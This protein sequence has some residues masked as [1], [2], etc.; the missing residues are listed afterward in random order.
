MEEKEAKKPSTTRKPRTP[1]PVVDESPDMDLQA[2]MQQM[3]AMM[4]AQ[5]Q[6]IVELMKVQQDKKQEAPGIEEPTRKTKKV[7]KDTGRMNKQELRRKYK[8][9]D[10]YV[11]NVSQG[12]VLHKAKNNKYEWQNPGDIEVMSIEDVINMPRAFLHTPWLCIDPYENDEEMVDDIINALALEDVYEYVYILQELD[13][14]INSVGV[15]EIEH[16]INL[17][18]KHG[19]DISVDIAI[20]VERKIR[21]K[22]LTNYHT[23]AE[24]SKILGRNFM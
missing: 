15:D 12:I 24:L 6:Q 17:S 7:R 20:L 5:Q 2:Q 8:G 22:E 23:I 10:I 16:A 9:V 18:K 13:E 14:D 3:M 1:K 4:M 19:F 11:A 21:Q